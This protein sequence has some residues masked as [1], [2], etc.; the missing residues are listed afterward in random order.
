MTAEEIRIQLVRDVR[1]ESYTKRG[2]L[3][4]YQINS[5]SKILIIGQASG[6]KVEETGILCNDKSGK[7]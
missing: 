6:R 3:P 5:N 7:T 4:V 1:N 2:I